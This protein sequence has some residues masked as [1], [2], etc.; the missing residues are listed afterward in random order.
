LINL[1][2]STTISHQLV[3]L[4]GFEGKIG[5]PRSMNV[6]SEACRNERGHSNL[7]GQ[8]LSLLEE[9][10]EHIGSPAFELWLL[11]CDLIGV[12]VELLGKLSQRSIALD[13][14]KR[15]LRLEGRCVVPPGSSAHGLS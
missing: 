10:A 13:G 8:R 15:H 14:G 3:R 1:R 4:L 6:R 2:L 11:R 5:R 9:A 7:L 12:N